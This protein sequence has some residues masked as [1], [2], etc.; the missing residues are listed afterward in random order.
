VEI[1]G[2]V[3]IVLR[4]KS[5]TVYAYIRSIVGNAYWADSPDINEAILW[6]L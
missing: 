1:V 5:Q 4:S 2:D 3:D 6:R